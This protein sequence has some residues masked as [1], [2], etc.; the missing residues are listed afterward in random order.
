MWETIAFIF[1]LYFTGGLFVIFFFHVI[2]STFI[3]T[4]TCVHAQIVCMC[5]YG[6][7]L[8]WEDILVYSLWR[9]YWLFY[10][11]FSLVKHCWAFWQTLFWVLCMQRWIGMFILCKLRFLKIVIFLWPSLWAWQKEEYKPF[12]ERIRQMNKQ[13]MRSIIREQ[14]SWWAGGHCSECT[15]KNHP[16]EIIR[17]NLSEDTG[18]MIMSMLLLECFILHMCVV[19]QLWHLVFKCYP[20]FVAKTTILLL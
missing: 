20:W 16:R 6:D 14:S 12:Q 3:W 17:I 9:S 18:K 10:V 5:V 13:N 8:S 2:V 11:S 15:K 19:L 4:Y 7:L 1:V